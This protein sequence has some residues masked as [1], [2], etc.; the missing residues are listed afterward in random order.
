MDD[1]QNCKLTEMVK[2]QNDMI[3]R[4]G[5]ILVRMTWLMVVIILLQIIGWFVLP[6]ML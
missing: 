4:I 5:M 3:A 1:E 2:T 6:L